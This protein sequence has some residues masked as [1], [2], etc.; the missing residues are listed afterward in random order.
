M[1]ALDYANLTANI[2][3]VGRE[4]LGI[5]ADLYPTVPPRVET[6]VD[7]VKVSFPSVIYRPF[8]AAAMLLWMDENFAIG[9][10]DLAYESRMKAVAGLLAQQRI[11]DSVLGLIVPDALEPT[12]ENLN[13]D[14]A[15]TTQFLDI[16]GVF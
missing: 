1:A 4:L 3:F 8:M 6:T 14:K 16:E 10:N 11:T 13:G 15:A 5:P 12:L 2:E 9:I 7:L